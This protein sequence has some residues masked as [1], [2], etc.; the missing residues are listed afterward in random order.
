MKDWKRKRAWLF[1]LSLLGLGLLGSGLDGC[2]RGGHALVLSAE[3]A[4][5]VGGEFLRFYA[6]GTAEYGYAVV[7]E[8][9]KAKGAYRYSGDTLYFLSEAFRPYFPGSLITIR[10]DTLY[11]DSGLHFKITKNKITKR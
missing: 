3:R 7:K 11:M 10:G 1:L 2:G 5:P 6:D 4:A 9:L 8:N